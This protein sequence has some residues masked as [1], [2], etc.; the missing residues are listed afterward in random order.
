MICLEF[1][2]VLIVNV[3]QVHEILRVFGTKVNCFLNS[4]GIS[5]HL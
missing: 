2:N 5:K 1:R 3:L 4:P